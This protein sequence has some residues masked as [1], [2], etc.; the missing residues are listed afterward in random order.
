M[1]LMLQDRDQIEAV[2]APLAEEL[3][4]AYR[5][6][7]AAWGVQHK[8]DDAHGDVTA[9]SLVVAET[10]EVGESGLFGGN[11]TV[12]LD[13]H[14]S[15]VIGDLS[16]VNPGGI[17]A[18]GIRLQDDAN[19][20]FTIEADPGTFSAPAL[21]WRDLLNGSVASSFLG[22]FRSSA[23]GVA[24]AEY[25][26]SP[27]A[28]TISLYLGSLAS[29]RRW[30]EVYST[31]VRVFTGFYER[32]RTVALGDGETPVFNAATY[33]ASGGFTWSVASAK[34]HR[35]SRVGSQLFCDFWL[36]GTNVLG[37]APAEL[38]IALPAGLVA[39]VNQGVTFQ[40]IDKGTS[41][42]GW[43]RIVAGES[44]VRLQSSIAGAGWQA[45]AG[46]DTTVRL[47]MRIEVVG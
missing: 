30:A 18:T 7:K 36:E 16:D 47:Q 5:R 31:V 17:G 10:L 19:T 46:A 6:I 20:D 40:A 14:Q 3:D 26:L 35:L 11:V 22:L 13:T 44:F 15:V 27:P 28:S 45:T 32:G 41:A 1:K 9:D 42:V 33:T 12:Q 8:D 4:S 34:T 29:G 23:V 38:N 24:P 43:A 25:N 37:G 39:A 21:I 2:S